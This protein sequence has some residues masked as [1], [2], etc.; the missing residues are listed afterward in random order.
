MQCLYAGMLPM[1]P[2]NCMN[3]FT[4]QSGGSRVWRVSLRGGHAL[5]ILCPS[6]VLSASPPAC[7]PP[8]CDCGLNNQTHD[9]WWRN[10]VQGTCLWGFPCRITLPNDDLLPRATAIIELRST[11]V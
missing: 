5:S 6:L 1:I 7:R 8:L 3:G 2:E 11:I 10:V 9:C 4:L